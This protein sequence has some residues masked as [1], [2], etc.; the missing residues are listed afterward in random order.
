M[1]VRS[2]QLTVPCR[3]IPR[4]ARRRGGRR[5]MPPARASS[6][7]HRSRAGC[8]RPSAGSRARAGSPRCRRGGP[9]GGSAPD[10]RPRSSR[11]HRRAGFQHGVDLH[12]AVD[13][14]LAAAPR[15]APGNSAA[16]VAMKQPASIRVPFFCACGP[17]R[18]SS[19]STAGRFERP[20]TSAFSITTQ[21][22]PTSIIPSSAVRTAP[23]TDL[24]VRATSRRR[25][26]SRSARRRRSGR[27]AASF[28]GARAASLQRRGRDDDVVAVVAERASNGPPQV[29]S[30]SRRAGARVDARRQRRLGHAAHR[31]DPV[32]Q[33][34][35]AGLERTMSPRRALLSA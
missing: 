21:R 24:R 11:R 3:F 8:R 32:A 6:S 28:R 30:T 25:R 26:G 31:R 19:P 18:T 5:A 22:A 2:P 33:R 29:T 17:T 1:T 12:D 20:R 14:D 23:K 13:L 9:A 4:R 15:S 35:A 16:P 34:L 7:S 27:P 10:R